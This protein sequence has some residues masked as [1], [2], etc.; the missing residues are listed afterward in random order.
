MI[1][2]VTPAATSC[3]HTLNTLRYADRV[4]ELK[5]E[6]NGM[7]INGSKGQSTKEKEMML[8]RQKVNV[9]QVSIQ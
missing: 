3:E 4:K 6:I 7:Q 1:A 5:K 2:N 8:A 9:T